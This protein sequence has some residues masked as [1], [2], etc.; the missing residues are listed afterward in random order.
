M[1]RYDKCK[2]GGWGYRQGELIISAT[3]EVNN[4]LQKLQSVLVD[5]T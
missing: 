3:L 2:Y 1:D 4:Q 5:T